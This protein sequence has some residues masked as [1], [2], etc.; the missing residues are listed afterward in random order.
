MQSRHGQAEALGIA[1]F[2]P[3]G[4]RPGTP[5]FG[6]LLDTPKPGWSG[7]DIRGA[8][9]RQF[10]RPIAIDTDVNGAA[11][12][13][14]LWGASFRCSVHIYL[15]IGTGIGGGL[16]VEGRPVHGL[17]HPE[18]GHIRVRRDPDD[19]FPGTCPFHGDCIEGLASGPAIAARAGV[20]ADRLAPD[21]PLWARVG[22]ELGE[23]VATLLLIAAPER[24]V[25][26]GGVGQGC[27]F[28]LPLIRSAA[29]ASLAGYGP[30]RDPKLLETVIVPP[31]LG[32][33]AGPLGALVLAQLASGRM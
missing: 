6:C 14:G 22:R 16:V 13:E 1:S 9:A 8:L 20:S 15:T 7:I 19:N 3:L 17:L 33:E 31:A 26:G 18:L 5:E 28:L 25:I 12:A 21:D 32:S 29:A 4:L 30:A 27:S 23:L 11:L 2:G 10:E 24:I